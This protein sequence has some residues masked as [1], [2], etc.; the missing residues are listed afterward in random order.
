MSLYIYEPPLRAT[1][2]E[3][4]TCSLLIPRCA[5]GPPHLR[6]LRPKSVAL[7]R[8]PFFLS[9]YSKSTFWV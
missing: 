2:V 6:G 3:T 8:G 9:F 1:A 5:A 7:R 4:Q